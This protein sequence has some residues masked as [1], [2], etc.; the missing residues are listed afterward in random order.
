MERTRFFVLIYVINALRHS[1]SPTNL[2]YRDD[3]AIPVFREMRIGDGRVESLLSANTFGVAT[4]FRETHV[5][6][7]WEIFRNTE[8]VREGRRG[9]HDGF[10]RMVRRVGVHDID[11]QTKQ[12]TAKINPGLR[13]CLQGV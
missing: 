8:R 5:M 3:L 10:V 4:Q 1:F 11:R 2:Q 12:N 13:S 9:R 6:R 7:V